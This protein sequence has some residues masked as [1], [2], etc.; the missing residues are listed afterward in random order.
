MVFGL[1]F[2]VGKKTKIENQVHIENNFSRR[3]YRFYVVWHYLTIRNYSRV[4]TGNPEVIVY[5][6]VTIYCYVFF[7]Y[8]ICCFFCIHFIVICYTQIIFCVCYVHV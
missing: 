6:C 7:H 5:D 3:I 2:A 4:Q 1:D 8:F